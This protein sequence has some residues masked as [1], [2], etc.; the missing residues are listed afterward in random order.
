VLVGLRSKTSLAL[1]LPSRVQPV[2]EELIR[3]IRSAAE[4]NAH[5]G[6]DGE[7]G[8]DEIRFTRGSARRPTRRSLKYHAIDAALKACAEARPCGH[9]EVFR[10]LDDRKTRLPNAEPFRSAGGWTAGFQKEPMRAS[11]WLSKRWTLLELPRF[12]PGP[13]K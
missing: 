11:V 12:T 4:M 2:A 13:K 1:R 7:S 3:L 9:E 8:R 5:P 6:S 10:C